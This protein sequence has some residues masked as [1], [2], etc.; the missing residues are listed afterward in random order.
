MDPTIAY[1]EMLDTSADPGDRV[2]SALALRD[3]LRSG[4]FLPMQSERR[5]V[6]LNIEAVLLM[7]HPAPE[8]V[9]S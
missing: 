2:E 4:G 5:V 3:W 7:L 1:I 6:T 8:L 9:T